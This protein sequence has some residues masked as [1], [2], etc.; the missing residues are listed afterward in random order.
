MTKFISRALKSYKSLR[1]TVNLG[2]IILCVGLIY[3]PVY[4]FR[5]LHGWDDQW[6]VLNFYTERGYTWSN[7]YS[8]LTSFYEGQYA[9]VNQLYYSGLYYLFA[10]DP[11][12]YHI[13][14]VIIHL[15]NIL[16]VYYL[17]KKIASKLSE[18]TKLNDQDI[19]F[20]TTLLFAVSPF[21]LEPVV[22]VSASKVILYAL[23]YLLSM[24]SY[25]LYLTNKKP[26][27]FYLTL[28]LFVLSFGAK[29][30]AVTL[31]FSLL[32]LDYIYKRKIK[33]SIIW[34]EKT[35]FFIASFL[36]GYVSIESQGKDLFEISNF[37][38]LHERILLACY[39]GSEYLTKLLFPLN[40]SYIYPFPFQA[41]ESKPLYLW[42]YP[43]AGITL[44]LAYFE[45]LK[46]QKWLVFGILFFIIH[47][48]LVVN[49]LSLARFSIV[50]DRYV[51]VASIGFYFLI[52]TLFLK[53]FKKTC[54]KRPILALG[55]IYLLYFIV[56]AHAHAYSWTNTLTLKDRLKKTIRARN[57]YDALKTKLQKQ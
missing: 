54:L 57:D 25:C 40:L 2:V 56:Y 9:P 24:H 36:F 38:S 55:L 41:G 11:M 46:R 13:A 48:I 8:I 28:L 4:K 42:F 53:A 22:W 14:S 33:D 47:L 7:I 26:Q 50:A 20:L 17:I 44:L 5:F 31:P 6:A 51:Y 21:N 32:L 49:L 10:Y 19:A 29:E 34:L 52:S 1:D 30:Q 27:Y 37:Y 43:I 18:S 16:L 45:G 23:F 35:P 3:W 39:T 15:L 12:Y